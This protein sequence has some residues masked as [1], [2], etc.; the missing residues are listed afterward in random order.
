MSLTTTQNEPSK[1]KKGENLMLKF[2][3]EL[4]VLRDERV[5]EERIRNL[6]YSLTIPISL[7]KRVAEIIPYEYDKFDRNAFADISKLIQK[8]C[9]DK[10]QRGP[11][12]KK[13]KRAPS[14][15]AESSCSEILKLEAEEKKFRLNI[16]PK[17]EL[18]RKKK[19]KINWETE[20]LKKERRDRV[21]W[22]TKIY[23]LDTKLED[24][25][26]DV[27]AEIMMDAAAEKF[28]AWFN[29]IGSQRDIMTVEKIKQLFAIE[30]E[31]FF[32]Q[33]IYI[34]PKEIKS[35]AKNVAERWN[36]PELAV[37]T[38][39]LQYLE[40][41]KNYVPPNIPKV[42]FGRSRPLNELPWVQHK[43]DIPVKTCFSDLIL[44]YRIVF[45]GITHLSTVKLLVDFYKLRPHLEVPEYLLKCGVFEEVEEKVEVR[46]GKPL[47]ETLHLKY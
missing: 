14:V 24:L 26:L 21:K 39:F 47:Y 3:N 6:D 5:Q 42:A 38:Q 28:I 16:P 17:P 18:F 46:V 25:S 31:R 4:E 15:F 44:S 1:K 20:Y 23:E 10:L 7:R 29:N 11:L 41:R 35:I 32:I 27:Q 40:D 37:E 19:K 12:H 8:P 30:A 45:A 34:E 13:T 2:A 22:N 33:S 36:M 9:V 43:K